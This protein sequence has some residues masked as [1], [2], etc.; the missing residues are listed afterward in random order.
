V[1]F[2]VEKRAV[3][4]RLPAELIDLLEREAEKMG[5]PTTYVLMSILEYHLAS[6]CESCGQTMPP[7]NTDG[8]KERERGN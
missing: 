1:A 3:T 5:R 7:D 2:S 8:W 4:Y 6:V